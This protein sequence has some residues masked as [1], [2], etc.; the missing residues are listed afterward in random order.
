[1][2]RRTGGRCGGEGLARGGKDG[3]RTTETG[4]ET[5][6]TGGEWERWLI[7]R[8]LGDFGS[9]IRCKRFV[10]S[11]SKGVDFQNRQRV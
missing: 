1:M 7:L 4:R 5:D 8:Y 6:I 11:E 2:G 10:E 9:N 3:K